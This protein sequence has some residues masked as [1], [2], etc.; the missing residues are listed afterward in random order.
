MAKVL[1]TKAGFAGKAKNILMSLEH[2]INHGDWV[3][4]NKKLNSL[5]KK[6]GDSPEILNMINELKVKNKKDFQIKH[7]KAGAE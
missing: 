3:S 7:K 2:D 1:P 5:A 6:Y 4:Y